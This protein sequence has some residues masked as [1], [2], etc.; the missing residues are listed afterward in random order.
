VTDQWS[1]D[2]CQR[3]LQ[4]LL[5]TDMALKDTRVS[6]EEQLVMS[7]VL[8]LCATRTRKAA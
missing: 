4:L 6:N 7:L 3:A 2:A 1:A 8:A 5:E